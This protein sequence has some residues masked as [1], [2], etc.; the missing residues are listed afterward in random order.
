MLFYMAS[1][2]K[3]IRSKKYLLST[4]EVRGAFELPKFRLYTKVFLFYQYVRNNSCFSL[5]FVRSK[6]SVIFETKIIGRSI[7]L[8]DENHVII[9]ENNH[10]N[11]QI[12]CWVNHTNKKEV[13]LAFSGNCM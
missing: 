1:S 2:N 3:N 13:C 4:S 11:K 5:V 12:C 9:C 8:I 6:R 7:S 10:V